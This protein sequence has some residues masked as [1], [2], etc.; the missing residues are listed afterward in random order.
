MGS[1]LIKS[2]SPENLKALSL[3]SAKLEI[4]HAT[5]FLGFEKSSFTVGD[6]FKNKPRLE[7]RKSNCKIKSEN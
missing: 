4:E 6:V 1:R 5:Q 7:L 3:V 2:T